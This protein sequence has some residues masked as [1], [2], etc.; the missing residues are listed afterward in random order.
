VCFFLHFSIERS[1]LRLLQFVEANSIL[2]SL[3]LPFGFDILKFYFWRFD[4][5]IVLCVCIFLVARTCD[6]FFSPFSVL[7]FFFEI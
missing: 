7:R 3:T 2:V 4:I 5:I 1:S 6:F